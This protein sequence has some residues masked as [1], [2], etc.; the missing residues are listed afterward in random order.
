MANIDQL[1]SRLATSF[2]RL[3]ERE[4]RLVLVTGV[5]AI[6]LFVGGGSWAASGALDAKRKRVVAKQEQLDQILALRDRYQEAEQQE[7]RAASRVKSN[8]TSLFSLLQKTAGELGLQLNDLN[9]RKVPVK[10]TDLVE[11]SV[12]VNLKEVSIDKLNS[13]LEKIEGK[14]RDDVVKVQ[15]L[16][17][18]TRF[19]APDMLEVSMTV[20]TWK[21]ASGTP[22]K[23]GE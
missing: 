10:D 19:D 3:S 2:S 13:F 1:G 23:E 6:L 9:E 15:K 20:A 8:T 11:V 18:K 22:A 21:P 14:R 12:D 5:V 4:R 16:K 17:V 7:K